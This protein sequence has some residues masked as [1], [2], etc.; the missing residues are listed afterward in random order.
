MC[1][2]FSYNM[3]WKALVLPCASRRKARAGQIFHTQLKI[4]LWRNRE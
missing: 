3:G 4:C 2:N 1:N